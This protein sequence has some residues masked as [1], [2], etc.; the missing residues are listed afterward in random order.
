MFHSYLC[1]VVSFT[2]RPSATK[3]GAP[4]AQ[5]LGCYGN[6][7]S[8]FL[9]EHWSSWQLQTA[10]LDNCHLWEMDR[11]EDRPEIAEGGQAPVPSM[12]LSLINQCQSCSSGIP[13]S[14]RSR[15]PGGIIEVMATVSQCVKPRL[16]LLLLCMHL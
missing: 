10:E 3:R 6:L 5:T 9:C 8:V 13:P 7:N 4:V 14:H 15:P 2:L 12:K 1:Q 11:R 16:F